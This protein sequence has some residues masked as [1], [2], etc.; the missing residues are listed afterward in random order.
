[1]V[2]GIIVTKMTSKNRLVLITV[3]VI[4]VVLGIAKLI[5]DQVFNVL[6]FLLVAFAVLYPVYLIFKSNHYLRR[7]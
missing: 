3:V 4:I 1:M 6:I 7:K 5:S 2:G